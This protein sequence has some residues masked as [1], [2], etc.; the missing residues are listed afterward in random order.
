MLLAGCTMPG[1]P[2]NAPIMLDVKDSGDVYDASVKPLKSG[3]AEVNG[4]ILFSSGDASIAAAMKNGGITKLHR[5][6]HEYS[7]ILGIVSKKKTI[8]WGE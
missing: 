5:V 6:D 2:V 8:V 7:N 1:G 3:T 4:I